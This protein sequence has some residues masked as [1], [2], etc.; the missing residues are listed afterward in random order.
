MSLQPRL[1]YQILQRDTLNMMQI[2]TGFGAKGV[3]M[4]AFVISMEITG[5]KYAMALEILVE[6]R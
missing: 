4:I 3:F 6:V 1:P 5:S 2:V